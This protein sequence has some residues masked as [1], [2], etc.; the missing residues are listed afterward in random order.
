MPDWLPDIAG[1]FLAL[2]DTYF[3]MLAVHADIFFSEAPI[4]DAFRKRL[5]G[6]IIRLAIGGGITLLARFFPDSVVASVLSEIA[7]TFLITYGLGMLAIYVLYRQRNRQWSQAIFYEIGKQAMATHS[8]Q[9][10]QWLRKYQQ[11]QAKDQ[12]PQSLR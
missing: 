6:A 1:I 2:G 11:S 5:R 3:K 10:H 12:S 9:Y 4:D 8:D 7:V